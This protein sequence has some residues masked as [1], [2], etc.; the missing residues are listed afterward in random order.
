MPNLS[1]KVHIL[2]ERG[3]QYHFD[4][5]VYFHPTARKVFSIEAIED[6]D[7]EWLRARI[8]EPLGEEWMFYFNTPPTREARESLIEELDAQ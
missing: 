7:A 5:D 3:Y 4:R 1:E 2:R 8:A 6:N